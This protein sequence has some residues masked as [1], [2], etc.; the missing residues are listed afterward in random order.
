MLVRSLSGYE[1]NSVV[2]GISDTA[3]IVIVFDRSK[4]HF[5]KTKPSSVFLTSHEALETVLNQVATAIDST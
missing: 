3:A 1:L 2:S 4:D 5:D